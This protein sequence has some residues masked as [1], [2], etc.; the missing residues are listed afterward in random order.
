MP[1]HRTETVKADDRCRIRLA[2]PAGL[3]VGMV[4]MVLTLVGIGI[5][6]CIHDSF[7]I[8]QAILILFLSINIVVCYLEICLLIQQD[9]VDER[10]EHWRNFVLDTGRSPIIFFLTSKIPLSR[11][12][13]PNIWADLW[14]IYLQLDESYVNRFSYGYNVDIA[15]GFLVP[16][17]TIILYISYSF[18]IIPA[19]I[20]G[21]IGVMLY[22]QLL[23]GT[24][25]YW[26]SFFMKNLQKKTDKLNLYIIVLGF[27]SQWVLYSLLGLYVSIQMIVNN[28]YSILGH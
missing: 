15:N 18:G 1:D 16:I 13:L 17:P 4:L 25:V 21:I 20:V 2:I 26:N 27:N 22:W 3:F 28:D 19:Q 14:A 5:H 24:L 8:I 7:D 11:A 10:I 12:F 23:Y 6:Y 9:Y